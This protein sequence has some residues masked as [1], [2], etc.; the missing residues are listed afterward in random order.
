MKVQKNSQM[1]CHLYGK[2]VIV[3]M[4]KIIRLVDVQNKF[5]KHSNNLANQQASINICSSDYNSPKY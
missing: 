2:I 3:I 5:K 1:I 4:E